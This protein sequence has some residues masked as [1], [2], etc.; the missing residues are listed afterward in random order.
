MRINVKNMMMNIF[1]QNNKNSKKINMRNSL[2]VLIK[3]IKIWPI[4]TR[5][6]KKITKEKQINKNIFKNMKIITV[7]NKKKKKLEKNKK[8]RKKRI[9]LMIMI[10]LR[11]NIKVEVHIKM[12]GLI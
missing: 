12:T 11:K 7:L 2:L 6:S 1:K 3:R 9:L 4:F 10:S 5:I 8:N